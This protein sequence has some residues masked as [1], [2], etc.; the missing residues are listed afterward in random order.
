MPFTGYGYGCQRFVMEDH[1]YHCHNMVLNACLGSG[2]F[3]GFAIISLILYL[4]YNFTVTSELFV[5][6]FTPIFV[7]GGL[8][9]SMIYSPAPSFEMVAF[10]ALVLWRSDSQKQNLVEQPETTE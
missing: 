5:L 4:I 10:F 6:A 2:I 3:A 9:E 7:L 8:I 1:H